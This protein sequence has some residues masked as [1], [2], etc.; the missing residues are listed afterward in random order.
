LNILYITQRAYTYI[1]FYLHFLKILI[2]LFHLDYKS[3]N[4]F[5]Y[6]HGVQTKTP[7]CNMALD[8]PCI[9]A[10]TLKKRKT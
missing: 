1:E 10:A 4:R 8:A 6:Q 2:M 5:K 3:K 7:H 9:G